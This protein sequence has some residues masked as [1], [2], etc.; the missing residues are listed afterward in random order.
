M[1]KHTYPPE[2]EGDDLHPLTKKGDGE[3][4]TNTK[5]VDFGAANKHV[6]KSSREIPKVG[7]LSLDINHIFSSES[8]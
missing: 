2:P 3:R 1:G 5:K 8:S 4:N 6:V 7:E